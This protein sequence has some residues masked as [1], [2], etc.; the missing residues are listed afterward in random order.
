MLAQGRASRKTRR[1]RQ[2]PLIGPYLI[3]VIAFLVKWWQVF[4]YVLVLLSK[5][6]RPA[7]MSGPELMAYR[8]LSV[9]NGRHV[10]I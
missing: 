8:S 4:W 1:K 9:S 6:L 10:K 2:E 3:D 7:F 5:D